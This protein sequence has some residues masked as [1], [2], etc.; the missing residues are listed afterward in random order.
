MTLATVTGI[1][2]AALARAFDGA[3]SELEQ[4]FSRNVNKSA[5]AMPGK[6]RQGIE[7]I[8]LFS[9][10]LCKVLSNLN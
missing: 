10:L 7:L 8:S 2:W 3:G 5:P 9:P 6:V 4:A 1:V